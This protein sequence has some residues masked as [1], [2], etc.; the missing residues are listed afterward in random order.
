MTDALQ[1]V[2]C[3]THEAEKPECSHAEIAVTDGMASRSRRLVV[4]HYATR[5]LEDYKA[6]LRRGA[7]DHARSDSLRGMG[8]FQVLNKCDVTR[9]V[10]A[11]QAGSGALMLNM[12]T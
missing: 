5:S 12:S 3:A 6:K 2:P 7:G 8:F 11:S 4:H 9:L 10:L 1:R